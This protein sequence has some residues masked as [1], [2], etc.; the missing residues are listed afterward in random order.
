MSDPETQKLID[1]LVSDRKKFDEFVYTSLPDALRL[2]SERKV[3]IKDDIVNV[4][5]FIKANGCGVMFRHVCTPNHESHRF[6]SIIDAADLKPFFFTHKSDKFTDNNKAK[7]NFLKM[8]I[9]KG[10]GKNNG[11]KLEKYKIGDFNESNGVPIN[12]VITNNGKDLFK[13]HLDIFLDK[14][15]SILE[16]QIIDIKEWQE[17]ILVDKYYEN[18]MKLFIKDAILFENFLSNGKELEF[19][20]NVFLPAFIKIWKMTGHKPLIVAL[21]PTEIEGDDFWMFYPDDVESFLTFD[22]SLI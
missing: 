21:E 19:T 5:G 12:Q 13:F 1:E 3:S 8:T 16:E 10:F 17:E 15:K 22:K 6:I 18:L 7:Y 2:M 11:M 4:P 20:K 9:F 14:Y